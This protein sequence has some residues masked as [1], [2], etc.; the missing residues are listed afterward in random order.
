MMPTLS[1]VLSGLLVGAGAIYSYLTYSQK[2]DETKS[3]IEESKKV[4]YLAKK[5][6]LNVASANN[7]DVNNSLATISLDDGKVS[8]F[9]SKDENLTKDEIALI[10]KL[11]L[12]VEKVVLEDNNLN[13]NCTDLSNTGYINFSECEKL[14]DKKFHTYQVTSSGVSL[15]K[16]S[17]LSKD[18]TGIKITNT[19]KSA[20]NSELLSKKKI[21]RFHKSVKDRVKL[22]KIVSNI[23][24]EKFFQKISKR[25]VENSQKNRLNDKLVSTLEKVAMLRFAK[26]SK[27]ADNKNIDKKSKYK[28][29]TDMFD[30]Y[31]KKKSV[32]KLELEKK[33]KFLQEQRYKY[34]FELNKLQYEMASLKKS[35]EK[36]RNSDGGFFSKAVDRVSHVFSP[37]K[38]T[39]RITEQLS[40]KESLYNKTRNK[41]KELDRQLIHLESQKG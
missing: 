5:N 27:S 41:I 17:I 37:T 21:D 29:I 4:I 38:M 8:N 1:F 33:I 10:D 7:L 24:D 36:K 11:Q 32:E 14:K 35:L 25:Y 23:E 2:I 26:N 9:L 39:D 19:L 12:A 30:K 15:P 18:E 13:P 3:K 28:K 6:S 20:S 22:E 40:S 34:M 31:K 16:N